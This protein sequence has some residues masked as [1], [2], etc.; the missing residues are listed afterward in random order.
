MIEISVVIPTFRREAQLREAIDS[1]LAQGVNAQI[2]VMDDSPEGSA[3]ET[4]AGY[5]ESQVTYVLHQ[6]PS[7]GRP[8]LVR[9]AGAR[10]A[11]GPLVH[12]LDD[13]DRV[14]PGFYRAALD[15]FARHP[16]IGM[17]FG[18]IEP[19]TT[20][21][22]YDIQ[23]ERVFFAKAARRARISALLPSRLWL[24]ANLLFLPTV[25]VNSA[26]IVRRECIAPVGGYDLSLGLNEDV[27]FHSRV[28]RQFGYRFLDQ[29]VLEYRISPD[30]LMHGR[31][32]DNKLVAAYQTIHAGY[33]NR[34]GRMEFIAMKLL[35]RTVLSVL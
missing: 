6:P 11:E 2:I 15:S 17:V 33:R 29:V 21:A 10:L 19:F 28:A 31:T 24:A 1:V 35:A 12:F 16:D 18:R 5:P 3:R 32:D 9:N 20:S 22:G 30:S 34:H 25:L 7:G 8:A 27:D 26:C 4:V 13:D 23:N 14:A